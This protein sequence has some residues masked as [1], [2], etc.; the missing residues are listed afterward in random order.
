QHDPHHEACLTAW[1]TEAL[2]L[3]EANAQQWLLAINRLINSQSV[4]FPE[5]VRV[6]QT[7]WLSLDNAQAPWQ[8]YQ[9]AKTHHLSLRE[10]HSACLSD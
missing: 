5:A 6:Y 2:N 10:M 7:Q 9:Q 3:L 8:Q 4:A 1:D